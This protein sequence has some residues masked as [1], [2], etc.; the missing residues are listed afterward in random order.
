MSLDQ[1]SPYPKEVYNEAVE[2]NFFPAKM[3]QAG[4]TLPKPGKDPII[5][6]NFKPISLPNSDPKMYV[7]ILANRLME[8]TPYLIGMEQVGFAKGR[9]APDGTRRI[10]N[11]IRYVELK[12]KPCVFLAFD[13]EKAFVW[14]H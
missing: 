3:H 13:A 4:I 7:K 11:L 1:S 9:Q 6:Q 10:I 2:L 14:V 8:V 12:H 5:S